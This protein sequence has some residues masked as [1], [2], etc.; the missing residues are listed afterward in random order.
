[1]DKGITALSGVGS[2][3]AK[4]FENLGIHT[5]GELLRHY[6]RGYEDIGNIIDIADMSVSR[7]MKITLFA[8]VCGRITEKRIGGGRLLTSVPICDDSGAA[9]ITYFNNRFIK[10]SLHEGVKYYFYGKINENGMPT[11]YNPEVYRLLPENGSLLPIYPL[12]AG[13][14]QSFMRKT[15]AQALK[16]TDI[17]EPLTQELLDQYS[18]CGIKDAL[19]KIHAPQSDED[20]FRARRA[21]DF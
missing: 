19:C 4:Y 5:A 16:I 8:A 20:I 14:S 12:T 17:S 18:L 15:V 10:N 6:P 11:L 9:V 2:A 21:A 13:L 3:R 7:G 1:M